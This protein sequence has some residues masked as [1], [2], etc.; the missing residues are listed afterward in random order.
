M[1]LYYYIARKFLYNV[2]RVQVA[3]IALL[4]LII[5][6]NVIQFFSE[7]GVEAKVYI[8]LISVTLP[9]SMFLTFPLV[10]LLGSMFTFL[11]MSRSSEMVIVRASGISA[12]KMLLAPTVVTIL[13]GLV[14]ITAWNPIL[15]ATI[16]K[17]TEEM[18]RSFPAG[19]HIA[20]LGHGIYP[21]LPRDNV[22]CFIDT[23]K[24]FAY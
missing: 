19:R 20:N 3:L 16:R 13:I 2:V 1:T 24:S 17:A 5:T 4:L 21:D 18:L 10:V 14:T 12:L 22:K 7:R 9:D 6:T 11:G 15:T 8:Q 23:V